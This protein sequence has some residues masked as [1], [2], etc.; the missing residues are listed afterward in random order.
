MYQILLFLTQL[1]TLILFILVFLKLKWDF[2]LFASL[3]IL[4]GLICYFFDFQ[5]WIIEFFILLWLVSGY[6]I[7]KN[8]YHGDL[9]RWVKVALISI[10]IVHAISWGDA[11]HERLISSGLFHSYLITNVVIDENYTIQGY[12]APLSPFF[13]INILNKKGII[14]QKRTH[15]HEGQKPLKNIQCI[16]IEGD[17]LK[18]II[19][20]KGKG[21]GISKTIYLPDY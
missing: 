18:I 11:F 13:F 16:P 20:D 6:F 15:L 19:K 2:L 10:T 8:K 12:E 7:F 14:F 4:A 5:P 1:A 9:K 21:T 17:S 3:H